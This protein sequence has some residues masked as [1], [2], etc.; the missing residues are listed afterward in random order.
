[1][2]TLSSC[3]YH[4]EVVHRRLSPVRHELRYRVFN[5]FADVDEL[6]QLSRTL[7]LFSYNGFNLFSLV[8]RGHGPGDGTPLRDHVW[9][10]ARMV[11]TRA[12]ISR[13]F[14]FCYPRLLGMIFN[15]ITVYYCFDL[16]D[17]L[18]VTLYEVN[19][20]FGERHTY[21]LPHDSD[22]QQSCEKAFYVSPFNDVS[23][24]YEFK[25]QAP[26]DKLNIAITLMDGESQRLS[27]WFSG[28]R[29]DLSDRQLLRAFLSV[30][31]QPIKV[32]GGIHL[33]AARL[34][35]KGLRPQPRP[36]PPVNPLS[37]HNNDGKIP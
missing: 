26:G 27:A 14:M 30:P 5:L 1:M 34:W 8:D 10:V 21:A 3:L 17:T 12:P 37:I 15:P 7:K 9:D 29:V 33:E 20:T 35:L 22:C 4:G 2:S 25:A 23:G 36:K 32:Y 18:L 16:H 13:I 19:N 28:S 6:P 31:A 11:K 24:R